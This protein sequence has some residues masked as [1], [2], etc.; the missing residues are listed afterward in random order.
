MV[1]VGGSVLVG[2]LD[3]PQLHL[4]AGGQV[5]T[6]QPEQIRQLHNVS[7]EEG[8]VNGAVLFRADIWG[9]GTVSGHLRETMLPI[10]VGETLCQVP[11]RDIVDV[12]VPLPTV[13]DRLR[14]RPL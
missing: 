1:L 13:S 5:V 11:M 2:R 4:L 3:S 14:D 9:G 10:R 8:E 7:E 6:L 12:F